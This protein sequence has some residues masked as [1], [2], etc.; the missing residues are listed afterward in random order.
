MS[1]WCGGRS[2]GLSQGF[3]PSRRLLSSL[4][5]RMYHE[6]A[7]DAPVAVNVRQGGPTGTVLGSASSSVSATGALVPLVHFDFPTPLTL[8][9][10]G[11]FVI[12]LVTADPAI[13]QWVGRADNPYAAATGFG[14]N[15][16]TLAS[17]DFNFVTFV[18]GDGAPPE[19]TL[20]AGPVEGSIT[21]ASS[22]DVL[23]AGSDDLSYP[24]N[25]TPTCELDGRAHLPC[26]NPV[27]LSVGDG[28][29]RF[30]VRMTDQAGQVDPSP[31]AVAWTV[32]T[33]PPSR[34]RVA[35]PRRLKGAR[36]TYRFSARDAIARSARLRFRC[37]FDSRR[38]K[39]CKS[40]VTRG[41]AEGRHILRVAAVDE[42]GNVSRVTAVRIVRRSQGER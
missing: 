27:T 42:A 6:V 22:A 39:P 3:V 40:R 26:A 8:E 7:A 14:C 2:G 20:Q 36:A 1:F 25:L 31:A 16:G 41:L 21:R 24:S 23:F 5:L 30:S 34:P 15:G 29:H 33:R 28:R 35:G 32:D 11:T 17:H 37:A 4:D 10:P 19:T 12:E 9:P 38:L 18:P 13:V